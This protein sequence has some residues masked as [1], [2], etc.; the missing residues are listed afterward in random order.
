M[1]TNKA[2]MTDSAAASTN[3]TV[4]GNEQTAD[5]EGVEG[6]NPRGWETVVDEDGYERSVPVDD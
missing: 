2:R 5:Q 4:V 3:D 1:A 6:P